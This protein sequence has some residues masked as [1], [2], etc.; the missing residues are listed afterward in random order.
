MLG[1]KI[2]FDLDVQKSLLKGINTLAD[3]VKVTL[4]PQGNCVV[5]SNPDKKPRVTKDGV[6]VAKEVQLDDPFEDAG[7]QLIKEAALKT[8]N[9]VGD[10]TTTSTVLAQS[11][12]NL[13]VK[14]IFKGR[15]PVELCNG[16][17]YGLNH[18]KEFISKYKKEISDSNI[19]DIAT[20]SANNDD[21]LGELIYS[22]Y[23][24]IGKDGIITV[25]ESSTSETSIKVIK[26]MQFDR[27]YVSQHFV[28]NF[29]KDVCEL[30]N[31]YILITERKI[32]RMK[33]IGSLL[34]FIAGENK[35]IL[36]IAS[37]YD[38]EVI[39]TLKLNKLQ[40]R[41]KVCLVKAPSYGEYRNS[42][43]NDIACL[44]KGTN[45]SYDSEIEL[46]DI[47]TSDLGTCN[48]VIISKQDTVVMG[49]SGDTTQRIIDLKAELGRIKD[50]PELNG[51]FMIKFLEERIAKL[52]SGIC[53]IY[54]GGTTEIEMNEKKDR[55]DDA[56][57]ATKA[58]IEEGIVPGGGLT[59]INAARE[60]NKYKVNSVGDYLAGI[61]IFQKALY[62]PFN[63]I[64]TN[65][66]IKPSKRIYNKLTGIIGYDTYLN[67]YCNM[68]DC[69]I[70]DPAKAARVALENS[71]SVACLFLSTKCAIVPNIVAPVFM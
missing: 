48:K 33:D 60:L 53:T 20:I 16:I 3:A 41:L 35:S 56:V 26:G 52:S 2:K 4:G 54:V 62:S 50:T 57:C 12:I 28:T 5:I 63:T 70:I 37:D 46:T 39:E 22:A 11:L 23:S 45:I 51:S 19:K 47:Q 55:I 27:G 44:T 43:L 31:P 10:A 29:E 25:Q 42:I 21:T 18:V 64:L 1:K 14:E 69:G 67:V 65:A 7:A 38:D 30:E 9:S 36:I 8:L 59:Y 68:Y 71:V 32:N 66:G 17:E 34:N 61:N 15:N 6:S 13:G 40:G 24:K 58:A 49:G